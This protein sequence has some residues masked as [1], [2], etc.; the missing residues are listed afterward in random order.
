[1]SKIHEELLRK[2]KNAQTIPQISKYNAQ[3]FNK[4]KNY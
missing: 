3:H 2:F 1:M 4:Y